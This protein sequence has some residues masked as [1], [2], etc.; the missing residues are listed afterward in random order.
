MNRYTALAPLLLIVSAFLMLT[1]CTTP[2]DIGNADRQITPEET[3]K[4][5]TAVQNRMVAWG[6]VIA[7]AKNLKDKTE[8]EVVGYPLDSNNRPDNDAKPIGRFFVTQSGYLET[9]DYAPGRLITVVGTVT[10]TRAGSVG[11][12]KYV[13]PV[14]T[15][16]KLH[17]WSRY[18]GGRNEPSFHFGVGVGISR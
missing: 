7:T 4:N 2:Y 12:A 17:L 15:V 14:V 10:E 8:L 6:G 3:A 13:Y 5:I 9:A 16:N 1:G 11:E 18:N